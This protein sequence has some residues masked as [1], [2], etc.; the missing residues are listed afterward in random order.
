MQIEESIR[1]SLE[2]NSHFIPPIRNQKICKILCD[3][4]TQKN[5]FAHS[6]RH[7]NEYSTWRLLGSVS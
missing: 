2:D 1:I 3:R 4:E 6:A 5:F 7:A